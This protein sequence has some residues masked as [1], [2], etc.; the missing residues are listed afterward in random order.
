MPRIRTIKPDFFFDVEMAKQGA[1]ARLT[2]IGLWCLADKNGR[3][4]DIPEKIKAQL[5]PYESVDAQVFLKELHQGGFIYRYIIGGKCYIE[6]KNFS[7]HQRPHPKEAG[8]TIPDH[9]T[10]EQLNYTA[11]SEEVFNHPVES[12]GK[13]SLTMDTGIGKENTPEKTEPPPK[14]KTEPV[15]PAEPD[16]KISPCGFS[17]WWKLC[18]KKVEKPEAI[19]EWK[20][21]DPNMDT[22][23]AIIE[24]MKK[25]A[26]TPD[27]SRENGKYVIYPARW[28]KRRRW[29]DEAFQGQSPEETGDYSKPAAGKYAGK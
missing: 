3:M 5:F 18:P 9:S 16:I 11:S 4:E 20:K 15:K 23:Q 10:G 21:I 7:K 17:L 1:F 27:I 19:K 2:F 12:R 22:I 8:S 14:A 25:Y 24:G 26:A 6:I 29:E 28:L 13:E